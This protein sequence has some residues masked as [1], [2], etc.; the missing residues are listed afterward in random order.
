MSVDQIPFSIRQDYEVHEWK[1][2]SAILSQDFPD[3]WTD[4]IE[5]LHSFRLKKSWI[6]DPG[7]RKS[8]VSE[9]IDHSLYRRGWVEKEFRTKVVVDDASMDTPTHPV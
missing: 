6:T 4:I 5:V 3:E 2:A 1:H 7:G 9:Y 8:K